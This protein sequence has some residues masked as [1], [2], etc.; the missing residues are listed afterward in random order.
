MDPKSNEDYSS[1]KASTAVVLS[2][3]LAVETGKITE[4]WESS[5]QASHS[6]WHSLGLANNLQELRFRAERSN[7]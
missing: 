4:V 7:S 1:Q 2:K 6:W 3:D 5:S